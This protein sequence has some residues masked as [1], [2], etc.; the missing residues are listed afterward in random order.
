MGRAGCFRCFLQRLSAG[1]SSF[2]AEIL[3]RRPIGEQNNSQMLAVISLFL[4]K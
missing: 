2:F 1:D 3:G 4:R